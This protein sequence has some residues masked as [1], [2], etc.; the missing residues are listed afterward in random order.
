LESKSSGNLVEA[1]NSFFGLNTIFNRQVVN[2]P[3]VGP[4]KIWDKLLSPNYGQKLQTK[5]YLA[6]YDTI[7]GLE[8][9]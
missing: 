7:F 1:S 5:I 3:P 9:T 6:I 4:K 2:S 8:G